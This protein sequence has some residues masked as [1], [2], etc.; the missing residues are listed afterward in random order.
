M[1]LSKLNLNNNNVGDE[2]LKLIS[3]GIR[4]N[5]TLRVITIADA[6][7]TKMSIPYFAKSL[8]NKRF[9]TKVLLDYNKIGPEGAKTLSEGLKENETLTNL[10][11]SHCEIL[12]EGAVS[13]ASSLIN[14]K[15]LLV[16]DLNGNKIMPGG[17]HAICK[18]I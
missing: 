10:H 7:I 6:G 18:A 4:L 12:E 2:G 9:L 3:E 16:L 8:S 15:N 13:L 1:K 14:K 17:C 5:E 11:L